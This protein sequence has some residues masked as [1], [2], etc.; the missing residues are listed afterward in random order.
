MTI[1]KYAKKVGFEI[2]G[3]L[4]RHPEFDDGSKVYPWSRP[5]SRNKCYLDEAKNEYYIGSDGCYI[6]T[7]DGGVI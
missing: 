7:A 5:R 1:R 4:T 3:K 2:Q 6:I